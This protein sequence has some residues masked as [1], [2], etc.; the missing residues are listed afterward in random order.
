MPEEIDAAAYVPSTY[1][2]SWGTAVFRRLGVPEDDA[3]LITETLVCSSLQGVDSHGVMRIPVYALRLQRK[4]LNPRPNISVVRETAATAVLD[5]D[6]GPGQVVAKHG[7]DL[8]LDKAAR[9][10]TAYV[11]TR[12]TNHF[13]AAAYWAERALARGMIGWATTN[14]PPVMAH[15]GGR[16]RTLGNNPIAIAVPGKDEPPLVLDM[17]LSMVAGGKL[18]Y[19]SK[20]GVS[21]PDDWAIDAEGNRTTDPN[22]GNEGALIPAGRHKGSGLAVMLETLTGLLAGTGWAQNVVLVWAD[23][24]RPGNVTHAFGAYDIAAFTDPEDFRRSVDEMQRSLLGADRMQGIDRIY[25]PGGPERETRAARLQTGVPLPA[26]I[27]EEMRELGR[28]ID[29]PF[30]PPGL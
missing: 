10:G 4:G 7:M 14:A 13:G 29:V 1:M 26:Q 8:A 5:G 22:A 20:R 9:C 19:A 28:S 25:M 2:Q 12:H 6:N 17:A 11:V 30:A 16:Q 24:H 15:W 3:A 23:P 21:I 27:V 18:R